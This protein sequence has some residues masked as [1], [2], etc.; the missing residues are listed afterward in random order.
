MAET[1]GFGVV[2]G[3]HLEVHLADAFALNLLEGPDPAIHHLSGASVTVH[4][5]LHHLT[6]GEIGLRQKLAVV[7]AEDAAAARTSVMAERQ[8]GGCLRAAVGGEPEG[9]ST[10]D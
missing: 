9:P 10:K 1:S 3:P 2:V 6:D 5:G 7:L 8:H 4:V